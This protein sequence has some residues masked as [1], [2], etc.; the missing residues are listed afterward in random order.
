MRRA[1]VIPHRVHRDLLLRALAAVAGEDVV[2]VDDSDAGGL[3]DLLAGHPGVQVVR[4]PGGS[5][6]AR[7]ANAGLAAVE[8]AGFSHAVV[9]NDDAEPE[10]GCLD[11]LA[12]AWTS[13]TGAVGPV[14]LGPHGVESAGLRLASWGRVRVRVEVPTDRPTVPVDALAGACLLLESGARFDEGYRH[15]MEDLAL[16]RDLRLQGRQVL[17]VVG[18]RCH[19]QGG[20]TVSRASRAAQR[21]GVAGH[22]RLVGGGVRTPIV[23]GL[24]AAQVARERGPLDRLLGIAEGWRDFRR[25]R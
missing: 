12:A 10:P 25:S 22:L 16:C 17:L 4:T 3:V 24:A 13:D 18:A 14:M 20:A 6:F 23:L 9:L 8:R 7:A 19:H 11:A 1:V 21:H 2:V 5:G 15:G